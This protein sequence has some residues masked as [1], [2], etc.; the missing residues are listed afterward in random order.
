MIL[1]LKKMKKGFTLVELLVVIAIIG[2]L[3]ALLLPAVQAAREAARRTMCTNN[4]K[5]IGLALHN[6]HSARNEFPTNVEFGDGDGR[7]EG[8]RHHTW[9][10]FLLPYMEESSAYGLIDF[11]QPAYG[12]NPQAIVGHLVTSL[13]CPTSQQFGNVDESHG[14]A[15]TNYAASQGFDYACFPDRPCDPRTMFPQDDH[16]VEDAI[17]PQTDLKGIFTQGMTVGIRQITDGT[18]HTVM[19]AEVTTFGHTSLD[20][21]ESL[22]HKMSGGVVNNSV[23]NAFFRSAFVGSSI[24]GTGA[25]SHAFLHPRIYSEVDGGPKRP[26]RTLDDYFFKKPYGIAPDFAAHMGPNTGIFSA[27][28]EH[29]G[30]VVNVAL[31]DGSSRTITNDMDWRTWVVINCFK[32]GEVTPNF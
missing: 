11:D 22:F 25:N 4:I 31:A 14:L 1:K 21:T 30:G 13:T 28:S 24:Y 26:A 7:P 12:T 32:D 5:Q 18:S 10:S 8:P 20:P 3:V 27:G 17:L 2:I 15:W 23:E 19:L 16:P 29:S 9:I 6:Y